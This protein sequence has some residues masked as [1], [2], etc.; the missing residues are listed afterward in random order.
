MKLGKLT[1]ELEILLN[2][3]EFRG[4]DN[5]LNGLQV[6]NV[7]AEVKKVAFA[8]DACLESFKEAAKAK[9]DLLPLPELTMTESRRFWTAM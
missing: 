8:V 9:A 7:N 4:Y 6:G 2:I 3:E 5:S 1:E